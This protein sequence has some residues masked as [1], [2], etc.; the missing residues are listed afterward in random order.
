MRSGKGKPA[1]LGYVVVTAVCVAF[2][3]YLEVS[4]FDKGLWGYSQIMP[5]LF[6]KIG[7]VPMAALC[8]TPTM[9]LLLTRR[10]ILGF[11]LQKVSD[12]R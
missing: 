12:K 10:S 11:N 7:V 6:G 9:I 4:A 1:W 2:L 8:W 3:V 5:T